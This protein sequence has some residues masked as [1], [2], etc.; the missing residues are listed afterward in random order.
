[1]THPSKSME[2]QTDRWTHLSWASCWTLLEHHHPLPKRQHRDIHTTHVVCSFLNTPSLDSPLFLSANWIIT[3]CNLVW[4]ATVVCMYVCMKLCGFFAHKNSILW[5][6][7]LK[8]VWKSTLQASSVGWMLAEC[9]TSLHGGCSESVQQACHLKMWSLGMWWYLALWNVGKGR[10]LWTILINATGRYVS[11]PNFNNL[12]V[13]MLQMQQCWH[14]HSDVFCVDQPHWHVCQEWKREGVQ[15]ASIS[16]H[17]NCRITPQAFIHTCIMIRKSWNILTMCENGTWCAHCRITW[18]AFIHKTCI[19]VKKLWNISKRSVPSWRIC[20]ISFRV[21]LPWCRF[22]RRWPVVLFY[23]EH[24][25]HDFCKIG[26]LQVCIATF[27]VMLTAYRRQN[28]IKEMPCKPYV[29]VVWMVDACCFD[30]CVCDNAA[31]DK[32][33]R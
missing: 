32:E 4:R 9:S 7:M 14:I 24:S 27:L 21:S 22:G 18:Q 11:T 17:S 10:R 33:G 28:M 6:C 1:M 13:A 5:A 3:L 29:V 25:L 8:N 2:F 16:W 19:T 31:Q 23:D 15:Q 30:V 26:T 20:S 12:R